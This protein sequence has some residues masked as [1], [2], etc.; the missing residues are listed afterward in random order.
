ME[1][2]KNK[3]REMMEAINTFEEEDRF[4]FDFSTMLQIAEAKERQRQNRFSRL[5]EMQDEKEKREFLD[6]PTDTGFEFGD[7]EV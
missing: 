1:D 7:Y 6:L 2:M 3:E 4:E 5:L